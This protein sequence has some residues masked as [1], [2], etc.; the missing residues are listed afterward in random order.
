MKLLDIIAE[1]NSAQEL[2]GCIIAREIL[3]SLTINSTKLTKNTAEDEGGAISIY[4]VYIYYNKKIIQ[5]N[6]LLNLE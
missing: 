5:I 2:Y 4:Q 1:N 6:L 3:K